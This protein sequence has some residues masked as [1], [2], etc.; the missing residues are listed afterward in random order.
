VNRLGGG[1]LGLGACVSMNSVHLD[2]RS[3]S[4]SWRWDFVERKILRA[5]ASPLRPLAYVHSE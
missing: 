5:S 1:G 2:G 3:I 4:V